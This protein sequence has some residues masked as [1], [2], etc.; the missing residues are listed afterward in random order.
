MPRALKVYRTA[1]G[2]HDAYV[3]APSKKAALAAWGANGDLF[4]IGS[5]EV[6]IDPSLM[7]EPLATPGKVLKRV[8][9]SLGE[10]LGALA[11][12]K[13]P[14]QTPNPEAKLKRTRP[15]PRPSRDRLESVEAQLAE[16]RA[17]AR[18]ELDVLN[19]RETELRREREALERRQQSAEAKLEKRLAQARGAYDRA[20][21]RW[22][23]S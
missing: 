21:D 8:R 4:A 10:H 9:G 2:F 12:D 13:I 14:K 7:A 16:V 6:V 18:T 23:Q 5:A 20:L 17:K 22:R 1:I 3:A 15:V 11:P 19:E